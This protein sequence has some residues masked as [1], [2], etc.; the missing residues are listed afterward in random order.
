MILGHPDGYLLFG[1]DSP[2][3]DQRATLTLLE[4]LHIPE[5][6]LRHVLGDNALRLL[7]P[8]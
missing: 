1:T 6:K 8:A 3:T 5:K 7:G 4:N 2:W